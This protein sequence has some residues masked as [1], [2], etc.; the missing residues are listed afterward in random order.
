MASIARNTLI[1]TIKKRNKMNYIKSILILLCMVAF[2][3]FA[4]A[5]TITKTA[6]KSTVRVGEI[7]TYT[8]AIENV[9]NLSDLDK[10]VDDFGPDITI[11][12][13][14]RF[15]PAMQLLT[16][17]S[18]S[19]CSQINTSIAANILT[20]DFVGCSGSSSM[21]KRLYLEVDVMFNQNICG[22]STHRNTAEL[23]LSNSTIK[24]GNSD[25]TLDYSNPI[26]IQ[27]EF[28]KLDNGYLYYDV[29]VSSKTANFDFV[30]LSTVVF[31]DTFIIPS[32]FNGFTANN[33][34]VFYH[35]NGRTSPQTIPYN[36]VINSGNL[37]VDWQLPSTFDPS[38]G[39]HL[40]TV[41]IK[42]DCECNLF[43][44]TNTVVLD[45]DD[46][47]GKSHKISDSSIIP[48]TNCKD[49]ESGGLGACKYNFKKDFE[50]DGN[51]LGLTM[52]GCKGKYIITLEN[53]SNNLDF[54]EI[55]ITDAVPNELKILSVNANGWASSQS[56]NNISVSGGSLGVGST[57]TIV[58]NFEVT[59]SIPNHTITNCATVKFRTKNIYTGA[60]N[61]ITDTSC[62]NFNTVPNKVTVSTRK[63]LCT[64]V[65]NQNC[66]ILPLTPTFLP[67]DKIKYELFFYNYGNADG[68][69]VRIK[70][71]LPNYLRINSP[72]TDIKVYKVRS[73]SRAAFEP[74]KTSLYTDITNS[75]NISYSYNIQNQLNIDMR[76]HI[77]DAFTCKGVSFYKVVIDAEI[78]PNV[79]TGTYKNQFIV[80][81]KD[82]STI[83]NGTAVSNEVDY[84][85]NLDNLI[86]GDKRWVDEDIDCDN[87]LNTITYEVPVANL[88]SIPVNIDIVDRLRPTNQ[89]AIQNGPHQFEFCTVIP[90]GTCNW[91]PLTPA[92]WQTATGY[93]LN[94]T[95]NT[96]GFNI[97]RHP[98]QP[99]TMIRLR[100]K[101][102]FNTNLLNGNETEEVCND[103]Q[104][105][106]YTGK[107]R[108][109]QQQF[110]QN[111]QAIQ[112]NI[113]V[114]LDPTLNALYMNAKTA[115]EQLQ[116]TQIIKAYKANPEL[117]SKPNN[118]SLT[119]LNLGLGNNNQAQFNPFTGIFFGVDNLDECKTLK[120]CLGGKDKGC[121]QKGTP[122]SSQPVFKIT[123]FDNTTGVISTQLN[124]SP[125][126]QVK[127]VDYI[128]TD[129]E[130]EPFCEPL[131]IYI[132][133]RRIV[134]PCN[135]CNGDVTNEFRPT[136]NNALNGLWYNT[137]VAYN[138]NL[139]KGQYK[140]WNTVYY[141]SLD[142]AA[143]TLGT[144]NKDFQFPEIG[145]CTGN[146]SFT[147]TAMVYYEDCTTC[148]ASDAI[149]FRTFYDFFSV[150]SQSGSQI[151]NVSIGRQ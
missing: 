85:V 3:P 116:A 90:G 60:V 102:T 38:V 69:D 135:A 150:G 76:N 11:L 145:N 93:T 27:K 5:Q 75:V 21:A 31:K 73:G 115:E 134:L 6:S 129:I 124:I 43:S 67:G 108:V 101:V 105:W 142:G 29:R 49:L 12:G 118:L 30:D 106:A 84:T 58:I 104:I 44:L 51:Q 146:Y 128:I 61:L 121:V 16:N 140:E 80:D 91:L 139:V 113:I 20:V 133:R 82:M 65:P 71:R 50:L 33:A 88:G 70:D 41:K 149:D 64:K 130:F 52:K 126:R 36:A 40:F 26:E 89:V 55:S 63:E 14:V 24:Y 66:G 17:P 8:I 42:I 23:H 1:T 39:S 22:K 9:N 92:N 110:S 127:K 112:N 10:I 148:F 54:N 96:N 53:C 141:G 4:E 97:T 136:N 119:S 98:L 48:T 57:H 62:T 83:T 79:K 103:L 35:P 109:T 28:F 72:S 132:G 123:G 94:F 25:V 125:S 143:V 95:S 107:R 68:V 144:V 122:S 137:S 56:G 37:E 7:F 138:Y 13:P 117:L 81:Y 114:S 45:F 151:P 74:C 99:C 32:C 19:F 87:H 2:A 78:Q 34:E 120:D 100:Y 15:G 59:T 111:P 46:V 77:L 86:L 18:W 147:I 47:C 131:E